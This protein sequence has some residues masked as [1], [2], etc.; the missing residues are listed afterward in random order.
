M[1]AVLRDELGPVDE[2]F[3]H[4]DPEPLAAASVAQVHAARMIGG[5]EVVVKVQRPGVAR[6]V[7]QDLDILFRLAFSGPRR[8][9]SRLKGLGDVA[10]RSL[11]HNAF[12]LGREA[13]HYYPRPTGAV[14]EGQET[15]SYHASGTA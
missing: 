3:D 14:P 6:V 2:M 9:G 13:E 8:T 4:V 7:E 11:G 1:E 10:G 15:S 12:E 5:A